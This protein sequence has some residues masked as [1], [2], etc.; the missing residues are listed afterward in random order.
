MF[1]HLNNAPVH[2]V[3][4]VQNWLTAYSVQVL[5]HPPYSP[6]LEPADFSLFWRVNDELAGISLDQNT[7]KKRG[8]VGRGHKKNQ[9]WSSPPPSSSGM[10]TAKSELK[11]AEA[12]SKILRNKCPS[13][14][15][16]ELLMQFCLDSNFLCRCVRC[17]RKVVKFFK[18]YT[19]NHVDG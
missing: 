12:M 16:V 8:K 7:L 3:T 9:H 18:V 4:I 2:T 6:D 14:T 15:V 17:A 1:F 10:S 13:I 11:S 19:V 5:Y